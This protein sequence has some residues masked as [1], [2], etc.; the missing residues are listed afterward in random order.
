MVVKSWDPGIKL[1]SLSPEQEAYSPTEKSSCSELRK[2][3]IVKV[4]R[5]R[6][7]RREP[8]EVVLLGDKKGDFFSFLDFFPLKTEQH[9]KVKT[10]RE[11]QKGSHKRT[12]I[13]I[14]IVEKKKRPRK[15]CIFVPLLG[16]CGPWETVE[17]QGGNLILS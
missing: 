8:A 16:M 4:E 6:E 5:A 7:I 9:K 10:N 13:L 11:I 14:Q 1:R 2:V 15:Q 12:I 3:C 17:T